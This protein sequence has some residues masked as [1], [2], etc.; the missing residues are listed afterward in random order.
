MQ[1]RVVYRLALACFCFGVA[2]GIL[3]ADRL[4]RLL[5]LGI[6]GLLA[7]VAIAILI[8]ALNNPPFKWKKPH[9]ETN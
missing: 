5:V 7:L 9:N 2:V 4:P 8:D 6:D 3:L 1:I